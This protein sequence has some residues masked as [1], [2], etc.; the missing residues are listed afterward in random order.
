MDSKQSKEVRLAMRKLTVANIV[1]AIFIVLTV[2]FIATSYRLVL[3][4]WPQFIP[5]LIGWLIAFSKMLYDSSARIYLMFSRFM[6]WI[7]STPTNWEFANQYILPN[8]VEQNEA[9]EQIIKSIL[10]HFPKATLWQNTATQKIIHAPSFTI[11]VKVLQELSSIESNIST[12]SLYVDF[13]DMN[14][15]YRYTEKT[16]LKTIAPLLERLEKALTPE[17]VK[18]IFRIKYDGNN[19]FFGLFIRKI[20]PKQI[21][22]FHCELFEVTGIEKDN[23]AISKE[24]TVIITTSIISLLAL[25]RKYLSFSSSS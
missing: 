2:A 15:P 7:G 18:Y 4:N 21:S 16:L 17:W 25:S 8:N 19:P 1:L 6:A 11:R 9:A 14:V 13:T 24:E 10:E 5:I 3:T 22:K 20:P 12:N 23:V